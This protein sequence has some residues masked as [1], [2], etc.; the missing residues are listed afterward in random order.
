MQSYS[1]EFRREAVRAC[2]VQ[3]TNALHIHDFGALASG[4]AYL[5]TELLRGRTADDEL[6]ALGRLPLERALAI[7]RPVLA[8]LA[9][10][11]A[12]RVVHRDIKPANVFISSRG[13]AKILDF[14]LA[15]ISSPRRHDR[16]VATPSSSN[17]TLRRSTCSRTAPRSIASSGFTSAVCATLIFR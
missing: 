1:K 2:R 6:R 5:V 7:V 3:H 16:A 8:C 10:A 4:K 17:S 9:E 14:G 11:H 13:H 15:K 12:E